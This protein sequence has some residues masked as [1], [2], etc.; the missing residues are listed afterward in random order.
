MELLQVDLEAE[1]RMDNAVEDGSD[2][3]TYAVKKEK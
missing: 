3:Y 1:I 2:E